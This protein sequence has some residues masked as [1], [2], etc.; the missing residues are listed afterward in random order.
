MTKQFCYFQRS[1]R[2]ISHATSEIYEL[3]GVLNRK[4]IG[5]TWTIRGKNTINGRF[6][7]KIIGKSIKM[8][9]LSIA[10]LNYVELP[11]FHRILV[12][13]QVPTQEAQT[14]SIPLTNHGGYYKPS[15]NRGIP[16]DKIS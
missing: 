6:N 7:G 12:E 4:I 11:D 2:P 1:F 8:G 15:H 10:M 13:F 9:H 14:L 16:N 5:K 3:N